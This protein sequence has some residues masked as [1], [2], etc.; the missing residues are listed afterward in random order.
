VLKASLASAA[1]IGITSKRAM[2]AVIDSVAG[3]EFC[4]RMGARS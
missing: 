3:A 1:A 2:A 4:T